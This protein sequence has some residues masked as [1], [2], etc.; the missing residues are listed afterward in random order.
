MH[1][2][3]TSFRSSGYSMHAFLTPSYHIMQ[4]PGAYPEFPQ[5]QGALPYRS[6]Y[7]DFF[8][9]YIYIY[10]LMYIYISIYI[11]T[12]KTLTQINT[13]SKL[14][15]FNFRN[16]LMNNFFYWKSKFNVE[17]VMPK[18]FFIHIYIL[19]NTRKYQC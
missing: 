13:P 6:F 9:V 4:H 16:Q 12:M 17:F 1:F 14:Y 8:S 18:I 19:K 3:S 11:H 15:I 5:G 10:I 2:T 7:Y